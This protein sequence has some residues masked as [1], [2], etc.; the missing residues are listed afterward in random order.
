[1]IINPIMPIYFMV[2]VICLFWVC[3]SNDKKKFIR[4]CIVVVLLF[5]INLRIMYPKSGAEVM[6]NELDVLF[7]IDTTISMVAEDYNGN[8]PRLDAVKED[9]SYIMDKLPG[10]KFSIITFD[11]S[12]KILIP[13]TYDQ[14]IIMETLDI[15][16]VSNYQ[17]AKGTSLNKP[18]DN[19]LSQLVS[20]SEKS[21]RARIVFFI[22]DGEI[23]NNDT[24]I[25]TKGYSMLKDYISDGAILGYGTNSGGKMYV[26]NLYNDE[27][28]YLEDTS[29]YPYKTAISRIDEDNLRTIGDSLGLDY[30]NMNNQ[31]NIDKK[32]DNILSGVEYQSTKIDINSYEDTYYIFVIPLLGLLVYEFINFKRGV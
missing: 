8:N 23:T 10:S 12:S 3:R 14:D 9:C 18:I 2:G 16:N 32:I 27:Y 28:E 19:M 20:S 5:L 17:F 31:S 15:I 11:D 21:N 22:S 30:I 24:Y 25:N 29:S 7:V 6:T 13:F 4:Q 26:K 1:M